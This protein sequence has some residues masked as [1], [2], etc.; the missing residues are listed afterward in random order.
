MPLLV[1]KTQD[2]ELSAKDGAAMWNKTGWTYLKPVGGYLRYETRF[3]MLYSD[4]G[5][6][7]RIFCEDSKISC[8]GLRDFGKLYEEDVVEIFLKPD[9]RQNMYFEYE[10]SPANAE[11]PLMV[12]NTKGKYHGWLPFDYA[13]DRICKHECNI[14]DVN[15]ANCKGWECRIFIPFELLE[16][17]IAEPPES[18]KYW[19]ANVCRID[20]DS[21]EPTRWS[22][23]DEAGIEFHNTFL[24]DRIVFE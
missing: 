17:L 20:Y 1:K 4:K 5:M 23:C 14:I 8:T 3:K 19:F 9:M 6:Y 2:F 10:L 21:V 12:A 22:W 18:D 15:G 13:R 16:G 11:L 24:Y 7:F